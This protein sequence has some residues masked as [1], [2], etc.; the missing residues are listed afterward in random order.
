MEKIDNLRNKLTKMSN[1]E[2]IN[3]AIAQEIAKDNY[4][5]QLTAIRTKQFQK[6]SEKID[7]DQISLFNEAEFV[8]E[9]TTEEE[10]TEVAIQSKPKKKSK[11]KKETDFFQS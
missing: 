8:Y 3:Y 2:L 4:L 11:K 5:E 1:D 7:P 6:T 9:N 10:K